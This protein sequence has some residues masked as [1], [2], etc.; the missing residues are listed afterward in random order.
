MIRQFPENGMKQLLHHPDNVRELLSL[1]GWPLTDQL[2]FEQMRVDPTRYVSADYRHVESD[3]VLTVPRRGQRKTRKL[4][5]LTILLE[6]QSEPDRL[7]LLRVLDYLVQIWKK[8]VRDWGQEHG[9]FAS[10]R[11]RPVLPVVFYTGTHN[12]ERIGTLLDLMDQAEVFTEVTP[13][14]RPLFVNLPE[15]ALER[16]RSVGPFGQVLQ[17]VQQRKARRSDFYPLFDQVIAD[18]ENMPA[19]A[20]LRWLELLSYLYALVYHDRAEAEHADL[21]ERIRA[22]VRTD[23]H[24]QEVSL[25]RK[26]IAQAMQEQGATQAIQETLVTVLGTRFGELPEEV[27]RTIRNT[28]DR[29]RLDSWVRRCGTAPTLDEVGITSH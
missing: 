16:L 4:L 9:S 20:R 14:F 21:E 15:L 24:R 5:W 27:E 8:Q 1:G 7:M 3:L 19:E 18:L 26:T 25:V 12:W 28:T 22:G 13:A 2:L 29:A 10:V 23:E 11:L 17:A 6:H